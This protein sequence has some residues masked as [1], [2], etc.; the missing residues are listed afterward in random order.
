MNALRMCPF[1]IYAVCLPG[2]WASLPKALQLQ[3]LLAGYD[4]ILSAET[5]YSLDS[6]QS[7]LHCI[8]QVNPPNLYASLSTTCVNST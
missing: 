8:K 2:D 6:Q 3:G 1:Y 4:C 5:I 7:L